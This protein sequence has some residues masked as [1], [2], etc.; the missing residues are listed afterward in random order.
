ME[1]VIRLSDVMSTELREA[2]QACE[3]SPL[4]FAAEAL[5]SVLA[6]RRL[7][8]VALGTHGARIPDN[9]G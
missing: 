7:P 8:R 1:L 6:E 3:C 2:C 5:E 9:Q 4:Q